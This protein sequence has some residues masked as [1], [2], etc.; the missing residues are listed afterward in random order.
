MAYARPPGNDQGPENS[1]TRPRP[2]SGDIIVE[3]LEK[4]NQTHR[5]SPD[6][7]SEN[8]VT[9]GHG[10]CQTATTDQKIYKKALID[11]NCELAPG[12]LKT[13]LDKYR[14]TY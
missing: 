14:T 5:C 11:R 2:K 8:P 1:C 6:P 9:E 3:S 7:V 13:D 12:F 4:L 10:T